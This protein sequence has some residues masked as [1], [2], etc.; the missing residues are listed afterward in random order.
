MVF[1]SEPLADPGLETLPGWVAGVI[2]FY[3][4]FLLVIVA[5]SMAAYVLQSVGMYSIADRR[6][7]RNAWLAWIPIG[8]LWILGSISDQYQYLTKGKIKNRRK[9]LLVLIVAEVVAYIVCF[10]SMIIAGISTAISGTPAAAI[11]TVLAG[12]VMAAISIALVVIT[13]M[14]YYDLFRSCEPGSATLF[15]VLSIL[16][17][18]ALPVVVFL[19]RK[20]DLGMPKRKD[21]NAQPAPEQIVEAAPA[22][23]ETEAEPV[24]TPAAEEA[25]ELPATEEG[26]ANPEE[27]EDEENS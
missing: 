3:F 11:V 12:L 10:V 2:V 14:C 6:G 5:V 7:I 4:L 15:L 19:C 13:Y 21:P 1:L 24:A 16:I 17:S 27:F 18:Y 23:E 25:Q 9:A 26:Y 8:N 20:K 22:A